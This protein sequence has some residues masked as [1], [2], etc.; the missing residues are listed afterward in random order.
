[1]RA[2][3]DSDGPVSAEVFCPSALDTAPL[4]RLHEDELTTCSL[5]PAAEADDRSD[6]PTVKWG[7]RS[8]SFSP[9]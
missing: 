9:F 5:P 4:N 8:P 1:M 2:P 7:Q 6:V 3:P